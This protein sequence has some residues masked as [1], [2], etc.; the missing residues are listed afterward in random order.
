DAVAL[1]GVWGWRGTNDEGGKVA[2]AAFEV[3]A[4]NGRQVYVAFE[5]DVMLKPQVHAAMERLSGFLKLRGADVAYIYLPAEA[6]RKV[7]AD[8]FLAAGNTAADLIALAI[9][10]LRRPPGEPEPKVEQV[11]TFDDVP[12][13]PGHQVLD[14]IAAFLDRYVA[15][16]SKAQRDAVA[17]WIVHTYVFD[18]FDQNPR[19]AVL[20]SQKQCGKTRVMELVKFLARNAR[21]HLS[22][23]PA[24]MFRIIELEAPTLL[25]D[26]VDTIFGTKSK[27]DANEDL[28]GLLNGGWERGA[29]V[30]R[31]VG[32]GAGMVP[33][34]FA[35]FA[36][37]ALAG[38]GDCLPDTL[39]SR[40]VVIRMGRRAQN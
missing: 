32:E 9:P 5:S 36:P 14:D 2:L 34:D 26:E 4:L 28:R 21:V 10:E 38:I 20:S 40:S 11:D 37:V 7:G 1:L 22:M 23:S 18:A 17:I 3:I 13:E 29:P 24:Y 6:G 35:T 31:V 25:V 16:P 27:N 15:W 8:D 33:K 30:G 19:L 12:D 39:M